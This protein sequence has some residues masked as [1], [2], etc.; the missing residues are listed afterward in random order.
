MLIA[1]RNVDDAVRESRIAQKQNQKRKK[2]RSNIPL[3]YKIECY[4]KTNSAYFSDQSAFFTDDSLLE[5]NPVLAT[6]PS[7]EDSRGRAALVA[8]KARAV[9]FE[10]G[11]RNTPRIA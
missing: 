11:I 2:A 7:G 6:V 5:E 1:I 9:H 10:P 4:I 3:S 8:N